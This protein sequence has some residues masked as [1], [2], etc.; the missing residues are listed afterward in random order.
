MYGFAQLGV[1]LVLLFV[2]AGCGGDSKPDPTPTATTPPGPTVG[3]LADRIAAAWTGVSTYRTI[4]QNVELIGTPA[5]ASPAGLVQPDIVTEVVLPELKRQQMITNGTVDAEIVIV[6][7]DVFA[8]GWVSEGL[9]PI[10][11]GWTEVDPETLNPEFPLAM[12][13]AALMA[14]S[15]PPYS[16]LSEDERGRAAKPLGEIDVNGQS[17]QAY[18]IADTTETGERVDVTLAM[19]S[20]DLPCSIQTKVSGVNYVTTFEFNIPLTITAPI[21]NIQPFQ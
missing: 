10:E 15:Q 2:V 4:S 13:I 1:A 3:A 17:C 7:S 12:Q 18:Q 21:I 19:N 14:P 11:G 8:R 5:A 9:A 16:G 6:G 20:D